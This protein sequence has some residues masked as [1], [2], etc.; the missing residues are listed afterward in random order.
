M[1]SAETVLHDALTVAAC[2][3]AGIV[4]AHNEDAV[5]VDADFGIGVLADGMGGYN[6]GEVASSMATTLLATSFSRLLRSAVETPAVLE[7]PRQIM[8]DEVRGTN[9]AIF[10]ASQSSASCAGMGTTLVFAWVL[11]RELH[12]AHVGDSRA[13][14]WRGGNLR[15]LT[16]DHSLLQ[17]QI[18]EGLI[19]PDAARH[20]EHRNL[21]TRA[22]GVE[23]DVLVDTATHALEPDDIVLLCSDGLNDMLE[24]GEIGELL[25]QDRY[26]LNARALHLIERAN[27]LGGRDNISVVLLRLDAQS[28]AQ[29]AAKRWWHGFLNQVK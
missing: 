17:E 22:L 29:P 21:V 28:A 15:R 11:G 9:A 14:L 4:R 13:Y 6:A 8:S 23:S 1:T 5:F 7:H 2:S 24:D 16:K 27:A 12:L 26:S 18:D 19:S 20:A 10:R 3:D 25:G